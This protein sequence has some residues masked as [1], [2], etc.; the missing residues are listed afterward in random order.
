MTR[1]SL[2][3]AHELVGDG[4][5]DDAMVEAE[6]E[7]A[8][9]LDAEGVSAIGQ[10]DDLD[11]LFDGADAEDGNGGLGDDGGAPLAAEDAGVG[12]GEGEA[13]DFFGLELLAAGAFAEVGDAFAEAEHGEFVG[14]VDDRAR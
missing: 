1:A 14:A 9:E 3:V 11:S 8:G 4:A 13:A 2:E 5:I 7:V 10:S 6:G 12:D